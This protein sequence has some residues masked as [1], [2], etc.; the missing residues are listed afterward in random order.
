MAARF[1]DPK[2]RVQLEVVDT[3]SGVA[4][5][6]RDYFAGD[7]FECD[8]GWADAFVTSGKCREAGEAKPKTE[9]NPT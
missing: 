3:L 9:K 6:G 1:I 8:A 2:E 4:Y 5:E 7:T